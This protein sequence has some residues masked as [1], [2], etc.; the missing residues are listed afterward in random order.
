MS[1]KK[2]TS[3]ALYAELAAVSFAS[4]AREIAQIQIAQIRFAVDPS[5]PPFE[6]K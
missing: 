4:H 2:S 5:Y 3:L 1:F 6:S